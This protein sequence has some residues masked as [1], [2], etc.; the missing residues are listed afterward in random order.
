VGVL[1]SGRYLGKSRTYTRE[2]LEQA[3]CGPVS[4]RL[5]RMHM[6]RATTGRAKLDVHSS[7]ISLAM[8]ASQIS[9]AVASFAAWVAP[10]KDRVLPSTPPAAPTVAL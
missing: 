5:R 3:P 10:V 8:P 2:K 7:C 4:R 1:P 6:E 9:L